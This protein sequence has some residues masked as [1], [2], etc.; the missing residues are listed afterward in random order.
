M[1]DLEVAKHYFFMLFLI[2]SWK[3]GSSMILIQGT[4]SGKSTVLQTVRVVTCGVTLIIENILSLGVDQQYKF[5]DTLIT[6]II[7]SK[8]G[9]YDTD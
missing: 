8:Q 3:A 9:R 2:F 5:K 1:N 4:R 7:Y 6:N